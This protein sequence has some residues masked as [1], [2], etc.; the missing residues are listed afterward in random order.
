MLEINT[1]H[2]GSW[3]ESSTQQLGYPREAATAYLRDGDMHRVPYGK[4]LMQIFLYPS[5]NAPTIYELFHSRSWVGDNKPIDYLLL[6]TRWINFIMNRD[7]PLEFEYS[8]AAVDEEFVSSTLSDFTMNITAW[9][10]L[11]TN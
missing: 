6:R 8:S 4:R 11:E 10:E 1:D 7:K 2:W 9:F 3:L 5:F